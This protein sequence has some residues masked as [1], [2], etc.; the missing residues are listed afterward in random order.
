M[1]QNHLVE[2]IFHPF[3]LITVPNHKEPSWSYNYPL[4]F[5]FLHSWY[6]L[7]LSNSSISR[8]LYHMKLKAI[9]PIHGLGG[10]AD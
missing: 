9:V 10:V 8:Q 7:S 6:V 5:S 3:N 2:H 1:F 4:T